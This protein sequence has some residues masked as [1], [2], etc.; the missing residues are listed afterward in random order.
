M[1]REVIRAELI[2]NCTPSVGKIVVYRIDARN[3][4]MTIA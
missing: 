4:I 3:A 2:G 1:P